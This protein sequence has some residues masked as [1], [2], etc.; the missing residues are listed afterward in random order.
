M[1]NKNQRNSR[2]TGDSSPQ[3]LANMKQLLLR[4]R[5]D[6]ESLLLAYLPPVGIFGRPYT[7]LH[8]ALL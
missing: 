6:A 1:T 3:T 2:D 7:I 4:A 5:F 8:D